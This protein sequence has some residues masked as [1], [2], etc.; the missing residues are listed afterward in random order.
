MRSTRR[1][2]VHLDAICADG[3]FKAS[4]RRHPREMCWSWALEWNHSVRLIGLLGERVP[5]DQVTS[6]LKPLSSRSIREANRS[7]VRVRKEVSLKA[8]AD[9]LFE[10]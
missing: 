7:I 6:R 2:N 3:Y 4:L 5:I 1:W 10:H 8:R 9:R